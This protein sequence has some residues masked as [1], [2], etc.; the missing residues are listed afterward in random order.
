[1]FCG[2]IDVPGE[3]LR[4][5]FYTAVMIQ[6][7]R[8]FVYGHASRFRLV[9][10]AIH[11]GAFDMDEDVDY[12]NR[13]GIYAIVNIKNGHTYIG[14]AHNLSKRR[15]QH[16]QQLADKTHFNQYLQN[17]YNKYGKA[18]FS[19][20]IIEILHDDSPYMLDALLNEREQYWISKNKP[21][22]N[23]ITYV[24]GVIKGDRCNYVNFEET[25]EI[26]R[27]WQK[28]EPPEWTK[29]VYGG[30]RNPYT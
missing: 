29:W 13:A 5:V 7:I 21:E 23:I 26:I 1:M 30:E 27:W 28:Y 6:S 19:F 2:I 9:T 17:A 25:Y 15:K 12:K 18:Y 3:S 10:T 20:T 24:D 8:P 16:M 22:Y 11:K 14:Q 4:D